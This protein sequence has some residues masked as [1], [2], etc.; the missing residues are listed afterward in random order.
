MFRVNYS[1]NRVGARGLGLCAYG[2][3]AG[4]GDQRV[5]TCRLRG[6]GCARAAS[7]A[8]Q[9]VPT[10]PALRILLRRQATGDEV[11]GRVDELVHAGR[12]RSTG[13]RFPKLA[14]A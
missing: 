14:A 3:A 10:P 13:G 9:R 7:V 4:R 5:P 12:L 6:R 1:I 8:W 2:G 11:L